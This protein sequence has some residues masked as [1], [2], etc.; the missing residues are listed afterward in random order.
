MAAS[1]TILSRG[2]RVT[3]AASPHSVNVW[4]LTDNAE[5]RD[6]LCSGMPRSDRSVTWTTGLLRRIEH[7][8]RDLAKEAERDGALDSDAA[9]AIANSIKDDIGVRHPPAPAPRQG[10]RRQLMACAT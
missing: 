4:F 2:R 5:R 10:R 7:L 3:G 6:Q 1:L 8:A 9:C